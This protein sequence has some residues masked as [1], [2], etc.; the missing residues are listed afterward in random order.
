MNLNVIY[1]NITSSI[2]LN[3]NQ[4][5]NINIILQNYPSNFKFTFFNEELNM[6]ELDNFIQ[7]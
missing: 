5:Q 4:F 2:Y 6:Y 1:I 7:R 3:V